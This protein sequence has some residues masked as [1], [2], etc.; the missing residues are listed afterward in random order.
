PKKL[1][2]SQRIGHISKII[3]AYQS[4]ELRS[5]YSLDRKPHKWIGIEER[6]LTEIS[7]TGKKSRSFKTLGKISHNNILLIDVDITVSLSQKLKQLRLSTQYAFRPTHSFQM[8]ASYIR[9]K[10][11]S[12]LSNFTEFFNVPRLIGTHL[13]DSELRTRPN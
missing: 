11:M 8:S 9:D 5:L 1:P 10:T 13:D 2:Y 6:C 3:R 7:L 12:R 4:C